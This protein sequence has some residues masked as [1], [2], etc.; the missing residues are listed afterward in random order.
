MR[1]DALLQKKRNDVIALAAKHGAQNVRVFGSV[2]RGESSPE[3]DIDFLVKM[4]ENR[5]PL[6]LSALVLDLR[7]LLGVKVDVVSEDGIYW[8]LR[9]RILKE[10]KPL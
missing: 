6:D 1:L 8:L 9:R 3:S 5:S 4:E 7:E 2:A 10:S